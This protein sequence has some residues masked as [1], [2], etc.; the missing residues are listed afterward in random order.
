M[1]SSVSRGSSIPR[2]P[3]ENNKI[4]G[5]AP[6]LP[7]EGALVPE[8]LVSLGAKTI[9]ATDA[10][11]VAV[12]K[13][14]PHANKDEGRATAAALLP[15]ERVLVLEAL[16]GFHAK[17]LRLTDKG[18]KADPPS[19]SKLHNVHRFTASNV[20][21]LL[22]GYVKQ[23][24]SPRRC[25]VRGAPFDPLDL[26]I[27]RR[28]EDIKAIDRRWMVLDCDGAL[29]LGPDLDV[30]GAP[31]AAVA[32]LLERLEA[33]QAGELLRGVSVGWALSS[34]CG[35]R[36]VD[37]VH[38]HDNARLKVHV[39]IWL[40][41]PAPDK[42]L[43]HWARRVNAELGCK[44]IDPAA[45]VFNQPLYG[46]PRLVD[47]KDWLPRRSG[48]L[49]REKQ[50]APTAAI[51]DAW[52]ENQARYAPAPRK[53]QGSP[54]ALR[55][56]GEGVSLALPPA[57]PALSA[58]G[59]LYI[60]GIH[61]KMLQKLKAA[62]NGRGT[63]LY[64]TAASLS[65]FYQRAR[66]EALLGE[67]EGLLEQLARVVA[68]RDMAKN[69]SVLERGWEAG[70]LNPRDLD[71]RFL[72][73]P[74]PPQPP[75]PPEPPPP[76][77]ASIKE[78][79][80][81]LDAATQP[82][83]LSPGAGLHLAYREGAGKTER[84]R[85]LAADWHQRKPA[86]LIILVS[87]DRA[88]ALLDEEALADSGAVA[89]I[90][91]KRLEVLADQELGDWRPRVDRDESGNPT[92]ASTCGNPYVADHA[93]RGVRTNCDGC[94][95]H[96][97]CMEPG[98][99]TARRAAAHRATEEGGVVACTPG[100][101][102]GLLSKHDSLG[103]KGAPLAFVWF[104]DVGEPSPARLD[105]ATLRDLSDKRLERVER[106]EGWAEQ[107]D[108]LASS[109]STLEALWEKRARLDPRDDTVSG[110]AVKE[111]W[112]ALDIAEP[113]EA[114]SRALGAPW[115]LS[116]AVRWLQS[117]GGAGRGALV[118]VEGRL[119][120]EVYPPGLKLPPEAAV[121]VASAT[122]DMT[123]WQP[124]TGRTLERQYLAP[125]R[126]EGLEVIQY[127]QKTF[128]LDSWRDPLRANGW[129]AN[130]AD[131]LRAR[132][133]EIA[134][135]LIPR[136]EQL[137]QRSG[138][139]LA[140]LSVLVGTHKAL[141][142]SPLWPIV[143][144]GL[145][146][147]LNFKAI[148]FRGIEEMGSNAYEGFHAVITL[149]DPRRNWGAWRRLIAAVASWT[150]N[151]DQPAPSYNDD[152]RGHIEQ[153]AGRIRWICRPGE[154][155][156]IAHVGEIVPD[157]AG[158]PEQTKATRQSGPRAG[159]GVEAWCLEQ[160]LTAI[161]AP[162]AKLP[163]AP[164]NSTFN[165]ALSDSSWPLW[166][167]RIEGARGKPQTWAGP[168]PEAVQRAVELL[169]RRRGGEGGA[170]SVE[171]LYDGLNN[172][173]SSCTRTRARTWAI[174]EPVMEGI[175]AC[176]A[177]SE[178]YQ[179]W[180]TVERRFR[181]DGSQTSNGYRIAPPP[182][183]EGGPR[184]SQENRPRERRRIG[185]R[186]TTPALAPRQSF[187]DAAAAFLPDLTP[188]PST[189]A[190]PS[191]SSTPPAPEP[192]SGEVET[193]A[194]SLAPCTEEA[195]N[196]A[197][198]TPIHADGHRLTPT[199]AHAAAASSVPEPVMEGS[200]MAQV[201]V[202]E[203]EHELGPLSPVMEGIP[204]CGARPEKY[205]EE[206]PA[207]RPEF[208]GPSAEEAARLKVNLP[209]SMAYAWRVEASWRPVRTWLHLE[210][211]LRVSVPELRRLAGAA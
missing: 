97:R 187:A 40:D 181:D 15:P 51:L 186:D 142:D 112:K 196:P 86:D 45:M 34:T 83:R 185:A 63:L 38:V 190:P 19:R 109:A 127:N 89:L 170:F 164:S 153:T 60:S 95:L 132:V 125:A 159:A 139:E 9:G 136:L 17:T 206:R 1:T 116:E 52:K 161:G 31:E 205:Q 115:A 121:V 145:L 42:A 75:E 163:G 134:S 198:S 178:K 29:E 150:D 167:V 184:S 47:L 73:S 12:Q 195:V 44:A 210:A 85:H 169:L 79:R 130:D 98:G 100:M 155:L 94:P 177:P 172:G 147:G 110:I 154:Q 82:E 41:A 91:R 25:I 203:Q 124:W 165:R 162:L 67:P 7:P 46:P 108:A 160:G 87:K 53:A 8:A 148:H 90:G 30:C 66:V 149:G 69:Q 107:A 70:A 32:R 103:A 105:V 182:L 128:N 157:I 5:A 114:A 146:A 43:K 171:L 27:T 36:K 81:H 14:H 35:L 101:L 199:Q 6:P 189:P 68:T 141:L 117:A 23:L 179:E 24:A 129:R 102:P 48:L 201:R 22:D 54:R 122:A 76:I 93:A 39:L 72:A 20:E 96:S 156:L 175:P 80:A 57:R 193:A 64:G 118:E 119:A 135:D 211:L 174:I 61:R 143:Q 194:R 77:G 166:A 2:N 180:L 106:V 131:K 33:T 152:A 13:P 4:Q 137:A 126:P 55:P 10:G 188:A 88:A 202:Q 207:A 78:I 92:D 28:K 208:C 62:K 123:I 71:P 209:P 56:L 113:I 111:A 104:D 65:G 59:L 200:L 58:E 37:E 120:L 197:S 50:A 3:L 16:N 140:A 144:E 151:Q 84:K 173:S 168:S 133:D 192:R 11:L 49:R 138:L 74:G 204:R 18:L 191:I 99:Y 183:A 21:E 176:G 26:Q 158:P